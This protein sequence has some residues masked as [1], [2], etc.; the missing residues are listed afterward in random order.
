MKTYPGIF[1]VLIILLA[2]VVVMAQYDKDG[3]MMGGGMMGGGMM[4]GERGTRQYPPENEQETGKVD[5][6]T[7]GKN[8]YEYRCQACHGIRGDGRGPASY[9]MNPGPADFTDPQFWNNI[10]EQR[11]ANSIRYGRGMMPGF[12]LTPDEVEAVIDYITR[13][14]KPK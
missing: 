14:Y 2:A 3:G 9:S 11:M 7:I 1:A 8:V 10:N 12:D 6:Y 5:R 4:G 13:T